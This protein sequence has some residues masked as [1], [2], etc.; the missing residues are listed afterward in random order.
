V[1]FEVAVLG[2]ARRMTAASSAGEYDLR[3]A[4]RQLTELAPEKRSL[5]SILRDH[6]PVSVTDAVDIALDVC[7][8]LANAHVNGIV[9]GD[10][11]LHRVR[12]FW[13]RVS[14]ERVDIFALEENDSGAFAF[15]AAAASSLVSPEQRDG[16]TVD[17][18]ADVWAVGAMLHWMIAGAPPTE[19]PLEQTLAK[20]PRTLVIAIAKCLSDDP[21]QRP[22]SVDELAEI[23]GSF[24]SSPPERFEQLAQRRTVVEN[25]KRVRSDLGDVDR[26][27]GRLDDAAIAREIGTPGVDPAMD[28]LLFAVHRTTGSAVFDG[29]LR[30]GEH[31]DEAAPSSREASAVV[32]VP[33]PSAHG[34]LPLVTTPAVLSSA[35]LAPP[36]AEAI[37]A[38]AVSTSAIRVR[39]PK[40][41]KLVIAGVGAVAAIA[42]G[43]GLGIGVVEHL[44][45]PT[46]KPVAAAAPKATTTTPATTSVGAVTT[47]AASLPD[48]H[49]VAATPASLPDAKPVAPRAP[50]LVRPKPAPSAAVTTTA[51]TPEN[52]PKGFKSFD[53]DE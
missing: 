1:H 26:V 22:D 18:R 37:P 2:E 13:P 50:R 47:T 5:A 36:K 9:H 19:E 10:L 17:V 23:L 20:A 33:A 49:V 21:S 32:P 46:A 38:P 45:A 52:V 30:V 29:P 44:T 34:I 35:L 43:V 28:R 12:T 11:G 31:A 15:R 16:R 3:T 48:A 40:P 8:E 7:D 41:W 14:G 4:R 24:A 27:L 42:V 6:G 39:R 51:E 25:A 53:S